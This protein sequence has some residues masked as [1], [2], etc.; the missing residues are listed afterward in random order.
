MEKIQSAIAKARAARAE[1]P[2]APRAPSAQAPFVPPVA[3]P[4]QAP[5]YQAPAPAAAPQ[6]AAPASFGGVPSEQIAQAWEALP[7]FVPSAAL[8]VRNRIVAFEGGREA[9][10]FDVMRTKLL[11]QMRANNWRR[12]AITSPSASCG[13]STIALNLGFSLARQADMRT[14]VAELDLRRPSLAKT[15]GLRTQHSFARV[16]EGNARFE[17]QVERYGK[18]LIFATNHSP[19]RNPAELLHSPSVTT[20]LA[21]IEARYDPSIM[22]FDMPPML[23]GD[24]AMAFMGQVDCVLLIAAAETSTIKEIDICERD[25]AAQ[26]NV[27]GVVLNKCRYMERGYGYGYYE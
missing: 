5:S 15:L 13:K 20:V 11:Q 4:Y 24:D 17:D 21:D 26:T 6:A 25:L 10:T 7:S 19:F 22:I 2:E 9:V 18:N 14:V 12:L 3:P 23:V 16:L 1:Q 8:M 27:L